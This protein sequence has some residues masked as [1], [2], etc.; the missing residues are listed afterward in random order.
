MYIEH[1]GMM[2]VKNCANGMV[3]QV[4]F[5]AAGWG[6]SGKHE[7]IGKVFEK[8]G[9]T[10]TRAT[11][12]GKWSELIKGKIEGKEEELIWQSNPYPEKHDW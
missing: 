11:F 3:C 5:K 6:N 7:I 10:K 12:Q 4:E 2:T 1:V 9:D 8:E